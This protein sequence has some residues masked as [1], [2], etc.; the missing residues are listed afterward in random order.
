VFGWLPA[1][2]LKF[3]H[4]RTHGSSQS[5]MCIPL[6]IMLCIFLYLVLGGLG[7]PGRLG[8]VIHVHM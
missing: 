1:A 6:C 7:C 2:A 5:F 8:P 4:G 3:G